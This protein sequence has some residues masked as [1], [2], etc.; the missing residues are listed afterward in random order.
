MLGDNIKKIRKS[1]HIS[2]NNLSKLTNISLGYLSDLE[3]NKFTNPTIEKLDKIATTLGVS[4]KDFFDDKKIKNDELKE[5]EY[6][7]SL[8]KEEK[9]LI[10]KIKLLSKNDMKKVLHIIEVFEADYKKDDNNER[11]WNYVNKKK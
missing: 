5:K 4:T 11:R 10:E 9:L 7:N 1:R 6:F 3:N 2:I 8:D